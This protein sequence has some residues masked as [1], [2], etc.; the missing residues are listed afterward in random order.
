MS[1]EDT[2]HKDLFKR[3]LS[4]GSL[5]ALAAQDAVEADT[6]RDKQPASVG[7]QCHDAY[8]RCLSAL[9]AVRRPGAGLA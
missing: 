8:L 4:H 5:A 1:S 7:L 2:E 3:N 6:V 9:D